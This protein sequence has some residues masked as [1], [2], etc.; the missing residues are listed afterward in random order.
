MAAILLE[1]DQ[2][3]PKKNTLKDQLAYFDKIKK[4]KRDLL[5]AIYIND[6]HVGNVGLHKINFKLK[7]AQFGIIIGNSKMIP[8]ARDD[9]LTKPINDPRSNSFKTSLDT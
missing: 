2:S 3:P 1:S 8:E 6:K 7:T 9:D 4:S 5:F